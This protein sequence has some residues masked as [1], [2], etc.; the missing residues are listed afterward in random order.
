M[1]WFV[2]ANRP[3]MTL[4]RLIDADLIREAPSN[5]LHLRSISIYPATS[6]LSLSTPPFQ[7]DFA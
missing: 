2:K 4:M 6:L 3:R 1:Q 5:P 7:P